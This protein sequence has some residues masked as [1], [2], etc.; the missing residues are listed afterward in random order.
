MP[1]VQ[2]LQTLF[3]QN[4]QGNAVTVSKVAASN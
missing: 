2:G 1:K 4:W 3:P